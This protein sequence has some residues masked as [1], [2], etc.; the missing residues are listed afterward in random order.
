MVTELITGSVLNI[1]IEYEHS[2]QENK[3][4][5]ENI[6]CESLDFASQILTG[7]AKQSLKKTS[8][9]SIHNL[10]IS[11]KELLKKQVSLVDVSLSQKLK[12]NDL[13]V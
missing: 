5:I 10:S 13:F 12:F 9:I 3:S 2:D 1:E 4:E 8:Y 7:T 11:I 6:I